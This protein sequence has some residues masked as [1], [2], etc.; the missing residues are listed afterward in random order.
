MKKSRIFAKVFA[1]TA[2]SFTVLLLGSGIALAAGVNAATK[3]AVHVLPHRGS[4]R[5]C[6]EAQSMIARC[7]DIRTEECELDVDAFPVFFDIAEFR[8][9]DYGLTWEGSSTCIFTSCSDHTIGNIVHPGDGITHIWN[10][11][12]RRSVVIP[13]WAQISGRGRVCVVEHPAY[14]AI[15]IQDCAQNPTYDEP[16]AVFC[17]GIGNAEGDDACQSFPPKC[18]VTPTLIDFGDV[19]IGTYVDRT[20]VIKNVGG[21]VLKGEVLEVFPYYSIVSGGGKFSLGIKDSLVVTVRFAPT[22]TGFHRCVIYT[23]TECATVTCRGTGVIPPVCSVSP[24]ELDFG[25]V[26]VGGSVERSFVIRNV[27]GGVLEGEVSEGCSEFEV[28][29]GSGAYALGSGESLVVVV[30][31]SPQGEGGDDCLIGTGSLCADVMC[32][33]SAYLPPLP[34]VCSVSPVELDFGEVMVGGSVERSFVIRNVGGGVLEGEVSEGCSEFEVISGSGAYSLSEGESIEVIVRYLPIDEGE[35]SCEVMTGTYCQS[36]ILRGAGFIPPICDVNPQE[37]DFGSVKV[38]ESKEMSFFITN[39]GGGRLKGTVE[40]GCAE[41]S[42]VDGRYNLRPGES[43]EIRVIYEPIDAGPDTCEIL[44]GSICDAVVCVG[45]GELPPVCSVSPVELDF[46]DVLVGESADR[47]F[48]IRNVGGGVLQGEVNEDCDGFEIVSG[49]GFYNLGA[50]DS[51]VV[52]VRFEP[53]VGGDYVC[54][55]NASLGCG[56]VR[57]IGRGIGP[58]CFVEPEA[59]NFG[60]VLV[61]N[62][63]EASFVIKNVGGGVL[64]GEVSEDCGE[65]EIISGGGAYSL[66]HGE[67]IEVTVRYSPIDDGFDGCSINTGTEC[68]GVVCRGIGYGCHGCCIVVPTYLDFGTIPV[69]GSKDLSFLILNNWGGMLQGTV[70]ENCD[71]YRIISGEGDFLLGSG[72]ILTV[73]VRFEPTS[74]GVHDCIIELGPSCMNVRAHGVCKGY[75]PPICQ[76]EPTR[77]EFGNTKLG[78]SADLTFVIRNAGGGLLQG[79]VNEACDEFEITSGGGSYSLASGESL[80]VTVRYSPVDLGSDVC[81][82]TTGTQCDNVTCIGQGEQGSNRIHVDI[83]PGSCPNSLNPRDTELC[84]LPVAILGTEAFDVRSIVPSSVRMYREGVGEAVE[85]IRYSYEDVATPFQGNLCNCH[86]LGG[87]GYE[88]LSLK[89]DLSSVV[90]KLELEGVAGETVPVMVS[91]TLTD[92]SIVRGS[93]CIRVLGHKEKARGIG[94]ISA[95]MGVGGKN[96]HVEISF[97]TESPGILQIGIYDVLGRKVCTIA[98]EAPSSGIYQMKWDGKDDLGRDVEPGI[99]LARIEKDGGSATIKLVLVR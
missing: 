69:G 41:F 22:K 68:E 99:Y 3:V 56:E 9:L 23:G 60:V 48:V 4:T 90:N 42:V 37:L 96:K 26:M 63:R 27:G 88:D 61:G 94:F 49:G 91:A 97:Y 31:Y 55:L 21:G 14:G 5:T 83:K 52:V 28:I 16:L 84:V 54:G 51:L 38:G 6:A 87:D 73:V 53:S 29:S 75:P 34:P 43:K 33:G 10:N 13:G 7:D 18:Q 35:D 67:S 92:G 79:A 93:D 76:V 89:F 30:R 20:F 11:C 78:Q 95:S 57:C 70:S 45:M 80:R 44:T 86:T 32:V 39:V 25:E 12:Q 15:R 36:V 82:V 40:I 77:L 1:I 46:G 58:E 50:R 19:P 2:I 81:V 66:S 85:P 47:S 72:E 59:L 74:E 24:V 8:R 17:A 65:F 98:S 62:S 71:H 64:E